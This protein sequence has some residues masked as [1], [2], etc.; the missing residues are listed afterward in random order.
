MQYR[1]VKGFTGWG[2]LGILFVFLGLG[3]I[4]AGFA[5]LV[6][7]YKVVPDDIP[8]T[9]IGE[10]MMEALM[11]PENVNYARLAQVLGTFFMMFIPAVLFALTV[12]GKNPFWLGF[13]RFLNAKQVVAAFFIIIAANLFAAPIEDLS[14]YIVSHFPDLDKMAHNLEMQ[15]QAQVLA[16]SNLQ[17]WPEFLMGI[18]IMAFFPALFEELFF[19]GA[20]QNL[21]ARWWRKPYLAIVVTALVFSLIHLSVYL[22]LSRAIL[23]FVLGLLYHKTRNIWVNIIAHFLNNAVALAQLFWLSSSGEAPKLEDMEP[24]IPWWTAIIFFVVLYVLFKLV[25]RYSAVSRFSVESRELA[26]YSKENKDP[27]NNP[28]AA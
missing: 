24:D 21:F 11:E 13:N 12:H 7:G 9:A 3:F 2:Q 14:R 28:N 20:M 15:Y 18:V 1:S 25:N 26:L 17:S 16:L 22:F 23:G 6:I 8:M 4:L 10:A 27:F 5:Q 19:R